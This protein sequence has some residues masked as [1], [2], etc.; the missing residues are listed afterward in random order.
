MEQYIP[1]IVRQGGLAVALLMLLWIHSKYVANCEKRHESHA[2]QMKQ[3]VIDN[4]VAMT[5]MAD[6]A[7]ALKT[8]IQE[9]RRK[10]E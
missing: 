1:E 5:K 3:V 2:E 7:D 8:S 10:Y 6:A 9:R 4:S